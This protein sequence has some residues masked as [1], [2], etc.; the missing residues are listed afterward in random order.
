MYPYN[1]Q[2]NN[3]KK[4]EVTDIRQE[5]HEHMDENHNHENHNPV[6][7]KILE[8]IKEGM[9]DEVDDAEYYRKMQ[10]LFQNEEDRE[11]IRRIGLDE[12][13]HKK[14]LDQMYTELSGKVPPTIVASNAV[15]TRNILAELNKRIA[16]ELEGVEYYRNLYTLLDE[17]ELRDMAL[18]MMM[19]EN[20]HAI[21]LTH[22]YSKYK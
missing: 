6:D 12:K 9:Q 8:L 22:L 16:G 21:K 11:T 1:L 13:K 3:R 17:P 10:S 5:P 18:E 19:D 4:E 14:M 7:P 20:I 15:I 2:N